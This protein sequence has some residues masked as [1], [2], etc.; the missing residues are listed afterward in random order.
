MSIATLI[1]FFERDLNRLKEE[2]MAYSKEDNLWIIDHD[3]KN[4]GGNLALHLVGNLNTYI[5]KN[6]GNTGY[7]RQRDLEFS[8][9]DVP[10]HKIIEKIEGTAT[11]ITSVLESLND[12]DLKKTYPENIFGYEMT[13]DYFLTHLVAHLSYH[14]GQVNYHRRLLDK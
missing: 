8:A 3:I 11:M 14:L 5:G 7:V 9:K 10:Q 6:L 13:T 2:V 4:C 1:K 12:D